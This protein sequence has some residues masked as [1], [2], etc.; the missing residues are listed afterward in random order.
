MNKGILYVAFG[1]DYLLL[2]LAVI[3]YSRQYTSLPI[4]VL[5]NIKERGEEWNKIENVS[6]VNFDLEQ[7]DNRVVKTQMIDH[8]PFDK[9]LYLDC[10]SVIQNYG[11]ENVFDLLD[12]DLVLNLCIYWHKKSKIVNIYKKAKF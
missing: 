8:T 10:D 2:T 11:I 6:F 5:T 7:V 1:S 12:K 9:T 4:C 3:K